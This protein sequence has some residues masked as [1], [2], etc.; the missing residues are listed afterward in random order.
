[1]NDSLS[2]WQVERGVWWI[3]ARHAGL[4]RKLTKRSDTRVV[5]VGVAGGLPT[6]TGDLLPRCQLPVSF[7]FDS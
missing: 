5:A 1:M 4:A 3:Q 6:R 2:A 7:P